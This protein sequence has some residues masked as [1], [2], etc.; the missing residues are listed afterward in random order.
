MGWDEKMNKLH[1]V[2]GAAWY[3]SGTNRKGL[4]M[5]PKE[6][7]PPIVLLVT[8]FSVLALRIAGALASA[9]GFETVGFLMVCATPILGVV[10]FYLLA[11]RH[12]KKD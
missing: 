1:D 2:Q 4:L 12:I 3:Y 9:A 5:E 6:I 7:Y 11:F 10:V 8:L